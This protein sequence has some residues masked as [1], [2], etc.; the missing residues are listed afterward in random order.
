MMNDYIQIDL[1]CQVFPLFLDEMM[2][3]VADA[4]NILHPTVLELGTHH[5]IELGKGVFD[6]KE[7][8]IVGYGLFDH[9]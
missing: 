4:S 8:L 9:N 3:R 2:F 6:P 1:F 7:R 5:K